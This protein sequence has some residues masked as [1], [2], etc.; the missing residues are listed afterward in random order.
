M[1]MINQ[2]MLRDSSTPWRLSLFL[3][4]VSAITP[5]PLPLP[6]SSFP[7]V[8]LLIQW[9]SGGLVAFEILWQASQR[10][11]S[12]GFLALTSPDTHFPP[13]GFPAFNSCLTIW[14]PLPV[15]S[16]DPH[17]PFSFWHLLPVQL[18]EL[19]SCSAFQRSVYF[20]KL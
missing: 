3:L 6:S 17:F 20:T 12:R 9:H 7:C 10:S 15:Q 11:L 4:R 14:R 2:F 8:E 1:I 13:F 18:S 16:S 19:V 5:C